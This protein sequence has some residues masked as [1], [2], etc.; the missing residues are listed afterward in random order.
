M[1]DDFSKVAFELQTIGDVSTPFQ[2]KYGWHIVKLLNKYPVESFE[3]L[4]GELTQKIERDERSNLTGQTVVNKLVKE[5]EIKVDKNALNQFK[6]KDWRSNSE[7]FKSILLTIENKNIDQ[8]SFIEF[9]K[10]IKYNSVEEAF[11]NFI[12]HEVLNYYKENIEFTNKEFAATYNE[13]KEGL[14]LFDLLEKKVWEKSKDSF[15][16]AN[17]FNAFKEKKYKGLALEDIKGTVISDYQNYL[18][19]IWVDSLREK[20]PVKINNIEKK[21]LLKLN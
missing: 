15:G 11:N 1:V 4:K 8:L 14:L 5:Y 20:Y 18:E 7:I 9:L 2:T 12:R 10:K 21:K 13:F 19:N 3:K 6:T 17:Y 16:L